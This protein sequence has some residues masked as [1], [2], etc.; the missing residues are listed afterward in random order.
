[1]AAYRALLAS[2]VHGDRIVIAGDSAGGNLALV[3][4]QQLRD[5][6]LPLPAAGVL[7]SPWADLTGSGATLQTNAK[8]DPMLPA[9]RMKETVACYA[10]D[11]NLTDSAISPL[12]GSF[13][14]LP[15]L[16][17]HVGSREVLL[18]DA[19]RV[20][21]AARNAGVDTT[22][23]EWRDMPHVFQAFARF[24]PEAR[25]A[26]GEVGQFVIERVAAAGSAVAVQAASRAR[27]RSV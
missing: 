17:L 26:L 18:D 3:L 22:Y 19:R 11:R 14:G 20:A 2:G 6:G 16:L 23:R 9:A 5:A 13:A 21:A 10:P 8:L 4:L 15:P 7:F 1:M 24:V 27:L 25:V 12:F